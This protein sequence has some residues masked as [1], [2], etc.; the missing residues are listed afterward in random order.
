MSAAPSAG[1]TIDSLDELAAL[2]GE[3]VQRVKDKVRPAL[4]PL[5]VEWLQASP[6][7]LVATS[8]ADGRCDVSP[9]GDPGGSLVHVFDAHTI[10]IA[11]R[12]GNR[13]VDGYRNVI[14]NPHVGLITGSVCGV[15]VQEVEDPLMRQIRYL[16]KLVDEL[17]KGKAREKVLRG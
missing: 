14:E 5:D 15:K 17:A 11:E 1:T 13:R 2:V 12:P 7:C 9:K 3:P 16:D 6:F 10:A 4:H 8:G